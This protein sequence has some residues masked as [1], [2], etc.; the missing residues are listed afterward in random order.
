[1]C[2]RKY[3]VLKDP[4]TFLKAMVVSPELIDVFDDPN[5]RESIIRS[6]SNELLYDAEEYLPHELDHY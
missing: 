6:A 3:L 2:L 1:M 5:Y 4:K